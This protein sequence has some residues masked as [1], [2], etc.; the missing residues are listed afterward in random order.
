MSEVTSA[1]DLGSNFHKDTVAI[2]RELL[3]KGATIRRTKAGHLQIRSSVNSCTMS[4]SQNSGHGGKGLEMARADVK[5]LYPAGDEGLTKADMSGW[6]KDI[7]DVALKAVNEFAWTFEW[8]R[9]GNG[10]MLILTAPDDSGKQ[11]KFNQGSKPVNPSVQSLRRMVL[12]HGKLGD[13]IVAAEVGI[14]LGKS[15]PESERRQSVGNP[16]T[17]LTPPSPIPVKPPTIEISIVPDNEIDRKHERIVI[18]KRPWLAKRSDSK[19]GDKKYESEAVLE[20]EWS[21]GYIDYICTAEGCDYP[22]QVKARSVSSHYA[23]KHT[24]GKGRAAQPPQD[25]L[26]VVAEKTTPE[27][28]R[29]YSPREDRV[30]ALAEWLRD[31]CGPEG[32]HDFEFVAKQALVWQHEQAK[33]GEQSEPQTAE[34]IL[35]RIRKLV[36]HGE[37][38]RQRAK[39]DELENQLLEQ[40]AAVE[41]AAANA[42]ACQ[43]RADDLESHLSTVRDL[44]SFEPKDEA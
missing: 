32:M 42:A 38:M 9:T 21:D 2:V 13:D 22:P 16:L 6:D 7:K 29:S 11:L 27:F 3:E 36:D 39:I 15:V 25:Q 26:L 37:Y 44:L 35:D 23:G 1:A 30:Q 41:Q 19:A 20:R 14:A 5:R 12:Q 10:K 18:H 43:K 40:M 4:L 33:G 28:T 31:N 24:K 34:E 8:T 17:E